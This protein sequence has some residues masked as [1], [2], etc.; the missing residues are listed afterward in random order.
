[1]MNSKLLHFLTDISDQNYRVDNSLYFKYT[2]SARN[3]SETRVID[4]F[5]NCSKKDF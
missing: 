5:K 3:F 2:M 1:M 4:L